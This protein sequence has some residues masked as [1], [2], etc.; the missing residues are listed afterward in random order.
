MLL[1]RIRDL[2]EDRKKLEDG[3]PCPLCGATDHPYAAGNIPEL[4]AAEFALKKKKT[5]FKK[6]AE[7]LGKLETATGRK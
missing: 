7:R 5:S 6:A 2:E 3:K 4:S 1:S